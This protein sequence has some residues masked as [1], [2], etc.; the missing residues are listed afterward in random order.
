MENKSGRADF[1]QKEDAQKRLDTVLGNI[2][3][4]RYVEPKN[5]QFKDFCEDWMK[6]S[7]AILKPQTWANVI[8]YTGK[9]LPYLQGVKLKP[10]AD[11]YLVSLDDKWVIDGRRSGSGAELIDHSCSPNLKVQGIGM[12]LFLFSARKIRAGE[13]LTVRYSYPIKLT[14]IPCRCSSKECRGT[15]RYL[16]K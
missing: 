2:R 11:R 4:N 12:R 15:L 13:E 10:P 3:S 6:K 8:E 9:R 14:R 5:I 16:L 1:A 7:K